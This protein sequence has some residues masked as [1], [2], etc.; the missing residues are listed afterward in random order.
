M[1]SVINSSVYK[2]LHTHTDFEELLIA[3]P[4]PQCLAFEEA[5][6][7]KQPVVGDGKEYAR[8]VMCDLGKW[9]QD[10]IVIRFQTGWWSP[11]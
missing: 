4:E 6:N 3:S 1:T 5:A 10:R 7:I 11:K 2:L 8:V 9:T